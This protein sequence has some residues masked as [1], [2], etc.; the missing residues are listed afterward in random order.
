M[1]TEISPWIE[2][3]SPY[4]LVIAG[5]AVLVLLVGAIAWLAYRWNIAEDRLEILQKQADAGFLQAPSS[6]RTGPTRTT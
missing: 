4:R 6:S 3:L 5:A 1:H 2:K